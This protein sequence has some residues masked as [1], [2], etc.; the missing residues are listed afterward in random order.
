MKFFLRY[1]LTAIALIFVLGAFAA[2]QT[3][4]QVNDILKRMDEHYKA[5]KS[6]K[7]GVTMDKFNSQLGE[8]DITKGTAMYVPQKGRDALVRID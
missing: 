1:G 8:H 4:A 7:T 6:L 3:N 2:T 5:L